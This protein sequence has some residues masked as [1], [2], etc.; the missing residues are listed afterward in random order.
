MECKR[1]QGYRDD[2]VL[3]GAPRQQMKI[4]GNSVDRKVS[5]ALGMALRASWM[6]GASD[7]PP[8]DLVLGDATLPSRGSK[9]ELPASPPVTPAQ[10][11]AFTEHE[12]HETALE[13]S[14]V[15]VGASPPESWAEATCPV[16]GD[17][18]FHLGAHTTSTS[19]SD[20]IGSPVSS[21]LTPAVHEDQGSPL[22]LS[23]AQLE[24]IRAGGFKAIIRTLEASPRHEKTLL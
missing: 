2:E 23:E 12:H 20:T 22:P 24:Q 13:P 3:V 8:A 19:T 16:L 10:P 9:I 1:A 18:A 15:E 11:F 17:N 21:P 6:G 5:L 14:E 7:E 4:I